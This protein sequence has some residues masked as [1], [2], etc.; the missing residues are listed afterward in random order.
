MK[1]TSCLAV[2]TVIFLA[3]WFSAGVLA[4][5]SN[6]GHHMV[7]PQVLV[8]SSIASLPRG[9]GPDFLGTFS[10]PPLAPMTDISRIALHGKP[11]TPFYSLFDDKR[12]SW[13]FSQAQHSSA[14]GPAVL[15]AR[16]QDF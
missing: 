10:A 12:Q 11:E 9:A 4:Q 2:S 14:L 13:Q 5:P 16:H 3:S 15:L 7:L 1:L 8:W 6:S